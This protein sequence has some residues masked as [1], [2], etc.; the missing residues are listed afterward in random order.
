MLIDPSFDGLVIG[1]GWSV[2]SKPWTSAADNPRVF[3]GGGAAGASALSRDSRILR[4][5]V[6][7]NVVGQVLTRF[8]TSVSS[9]A[10]AVLMG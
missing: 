1:G 10:S 2:L 5:S 7:R 4:A 8:S 6:I 9:V 3:G